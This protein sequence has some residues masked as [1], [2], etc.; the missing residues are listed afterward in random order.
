VESPE[1]AAMTAEL[2]RRLEQALERLDDEFRTLVVLRDV[3]DMTYEQI[4]QVLEVPVGTVKSRLHRA[5]C[6]LREELGDLI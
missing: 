6:A 3:E 1:A 2:N 4:A 5:R